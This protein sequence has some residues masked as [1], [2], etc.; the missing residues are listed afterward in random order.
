MPLALLSAR[1]G[2]DGAALEAETIKDSQGTVKDEVSAGN[3]DG[4][5]HRMTAPGAIRAEVQA[6]ASS[7]AMAFRAGYAATAGIKS[8][9]GGWNAPANAG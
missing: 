5:R 6:D 7:K 8:F 3:P 1:S 4:N 2:Q 9:E